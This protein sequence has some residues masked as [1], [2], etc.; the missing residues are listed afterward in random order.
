MCGVCMQRVGVCACDQLK[1]RA[2]LCVYSYERHSKCKRV[3]CVATHY[4][5]KH[6][7]VWPACVGRALL[8]PELRHNEQHTASSSTQRRRQRKDAGVRKKRA[9]WQLGACE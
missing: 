7:C 8:G 1:M 2:F 9:H 3:G 4:G 6:D 5:G